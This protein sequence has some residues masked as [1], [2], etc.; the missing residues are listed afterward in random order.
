MILGRVG[1]LKDPRSSTG[2]RGWGQ[3]HKLRWQSSWTLTRA[4]LPRWLSGEEPACQCGRCWLDPW[5]GKIPWR[6]K[7]Q[8]SSSILALDM[9]WTEQPGRLQST[10]TQ[11][12][13]HDLMTEHAEDGGNQEPD[14]RK[15]EPRGM[16]GTGGIV[17]VPHGSRVHLKWVVRAMWTMSS[18]KV[19]SFQRG[20]RFQGWG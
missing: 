1:K 13:E 4:G 14:V 2:E 16:K 5:V 17:Q 8:P 7:W 19:G 11:R 12:I 6:R 15:F 18:L 20:D 3:C 10:G 9:P